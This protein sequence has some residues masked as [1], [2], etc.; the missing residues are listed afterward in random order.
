MILSIIDNGRGMTQEQID[1]LLHSK[2]KKTNGLSAIGVPNVR[3][4]LELYYEEKGGLIY[5]SSEQGTTASIFL[6]V[7]REQE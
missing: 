1:T 7:Q 3:E 6:P 2:A 4:R 5:E